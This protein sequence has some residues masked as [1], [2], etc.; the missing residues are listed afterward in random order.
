MP[1]PSK[2]ESVLK[3]F[4]ENS[5]LRHWHFHEIVSKA[6][7][8]KAVANK[9]L[10]KYT[11]KGLLKHVKEKGQFPY[12]TTGKNNLVYQS[13]KRLYSLE[14]MHKVGLIQKLLSIKEA[15]TI[16]LFGSMIKGDWYK[17]SDIDIFFYGN[18][19]NFDKSIY[20]QKLSR[21]IQLH[22]F[23]TKEEIMEV[24][25]GLIQNVIDGYVVKGTIQNFIK[26]Q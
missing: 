20:E 13:L 24:K 16:I 15:S 5:P 3:L 17:D 11:A 4:L 25:T 6:K 26:I 21:H 14:K 12:Y 1:S 2:E 23:K 19:G 8:T 18:L 10:K 7:I 9:W 22:L